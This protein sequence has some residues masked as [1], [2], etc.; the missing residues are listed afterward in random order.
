MLE[1]YFAREQSDWA[2]EKTKNKRRGGG[3]RTPLP[4]LVACEAPYGFILR[5]YPMLL[6]QVASP[7]FPHPSS[8][9]VLSHSLLNKGIEH[10]PLVMYEHTPPPI[11]LLGTMAY[12]SIYVCDRPGGN[13]GREWSVRE[14]RSGRGSSPM[15]GTF[16]IR[17]LEK[18][19][20]VLWV[21]MSRKLLVTSQ[22]MYISY[23]IF[24]VTSALLS[25]CNQ[26]KSLMTRNQ[27]VLTFKLVFKTSVC[28][29]TGHPLHGSKSPFKC[30]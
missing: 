29:L 20:L 23:S 21:I 17:I 26:K 14:G 30:I 25:V 11:S 3:W 18:F 13:D 28:S 8:N 7:P 4:I 27:D 15:E 9:R 16:K 19:Q 10:N 2:R 12:M 6:G 24:Q 5:S 22:N 1:G